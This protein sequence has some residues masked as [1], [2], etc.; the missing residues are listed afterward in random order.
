MNRRDRRMEEIKGIYR[1]GLPKWGLE[2]ADE[3]M[4]FEASDGEVPA[5]AVPR[6]VQQAVSCIHEYLYDRRLTVSWMKEQCRLNGKN[7]ASKFKHYVGETPQKYWLYHRIEVAKILLKDE[8]LAGVSISDI[9]FE[10][11]FNSPQAFS[12][13]FKKYTD[14]SPK[15]FRDSDIAPSEEGNGKS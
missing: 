12:T 2:I 3:T 8:A 4:V 14:C 10:V 11:G 5:K 15:A 6:G 7:F 1:T 9:A 13:T